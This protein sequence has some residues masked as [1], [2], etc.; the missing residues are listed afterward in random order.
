MLQLVKSSLI[1]PVNFSLSR[2]VNMTRA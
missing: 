2:D 1:V